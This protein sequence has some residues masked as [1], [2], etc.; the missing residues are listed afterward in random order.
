MVINIMRSNKT[1]IGIVF[2]LVIVSVVILAGQKPAETGPIKIGFIGALSGDG[3]PFGDTEKGATEMAVDKIN[4]EGGVS[5]RQLQVIYEDG[6]CNGKDATLAI[7]KLINIDKVRVVMGG[8]CSSET[9]AIAPIAEQNKALLFSA[10]SSNPAI[11]NSGDYIFRNAPSDSDVAKLD[12]KVVAD[13]GFKKLAIISENADYSQGVRSVMKSSLASSSVSVVLD[14]N[15]EVGTV[16]FRDLVVK[17]KQTGAD[18]IYINPGSSGKTGALFVKQLRQSGSNLAVHGNFSLGTPDAF[19]VAAGYL[20]G[21]VI[22]DSVAS[23]QSLKSLL[24]DYQTKFGNKAA[25]DFE[26]GA[27]YDRANI[28]ANAIKSVGYDATKIK[29]YLYSMPDYDGVIGKY[30][31]DSNGDVVGGPFFTE[32][33]ILGQ[34]KKVLAQ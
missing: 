22:S 18:L 27:T 16:D 8:L 24:G 2:V 21:V 33:I 6:K 31:F 12:A 17:V 30:K 10:F 15:F 34:T 19:S 13:E 14:E 7:Q 20:D 4:S 29:Q 26:F 5:G 3:A 25:N 11:T 23:S 32:Y 1:I 9:L 28:I